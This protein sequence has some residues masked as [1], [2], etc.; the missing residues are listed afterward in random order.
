MMAVIL[1]D[2]SGLS[3]ADPRHA[4]PLAGVNYMIIPVA[5]MRTGLAVQTIRNELSKY[6]E[7]FDPPTYQPRPGG[8]WG[9]RLLTERDLDTLRQMHPF[10]SSFK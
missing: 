2:L 1:T 3:V 6:P 9:R 4:P 10:S 7:R 8:S 5:A